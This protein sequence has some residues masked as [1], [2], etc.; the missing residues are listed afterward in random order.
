MGATPAAAPAAAPAAPADSAAP[1]LLLAIPAA[2]LHRVKG[3]QNQLVASG[4]LTI[5]AVDKPAPQ[6]QLAGQPAAVGASGSHLYPAMYEGKQGSEDGV[7]GSSIVAAVGDYSF[8]IRAAS[9]TLKV[10]EVTFVFSTEEKDVYLSVTLAA[11]TDADALG[12]LEAIL[13][14]MSVYRESE[15]LLA[16]PAAQAGEAVIADHAYRSSLAKNVH[17]M[18]KKLASGLLAS[19]TYASAGLSKGAAYFTPAEATATPVVV[20]ASL[21]NRIR[22]TESMAKYTAKAVNSAVSGL[23]WVGAKVA[24]GLLWMVGADKPTQPGEE[25]GTLREVSRAA[26]LGFTEVWDGLEDAGRV[27]LVSAR[28]NTAQV[29]R[30]RYGEDAAEATTHSMNT[31]GHSA[32]AVYAVRKIGVKTVAKS[33]AKRTAKGVI[34]KWAAVDSA[35]AGQGASSSAVVAGAPTAR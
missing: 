21:K 15:K 14:S 27:V 4:P 8:N 22:Q 33:A 5:S 28:D 24:G 10:G 7:G 18:S 3:S 9:Q 19:A 13:E 17:N 16:D 32:D 30:Q 26:L 1:A 31:A 6:Q 25:E 20:S 29:V 23:A 35:A 2:D 34:Q 12:M 11:D